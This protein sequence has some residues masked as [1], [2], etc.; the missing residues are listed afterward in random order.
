MVEQLLWEPSR[1]KYT[2]VMLKGISHGCQ[3]N[4]EARQPVSHIL[5]ILARDPSKLALTSL[6]QIM[7]QRLALQVIQANNCMVG[8]RTWLCS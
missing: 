6:V 2:S 8:R 5:C 7:V 3:P 1:S 4:P